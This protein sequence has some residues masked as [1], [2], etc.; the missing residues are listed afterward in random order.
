MIFIIRPTYKRYEVCTIIT[1]INPALQNVSREKKKKYVMCWLA[2]SHERW[3]MVR[4][5]RKSFPTITALID[6]RNTV[7]GV[8]YQH[9]AERFGRSKSILVHSIMLYQIRTYPQV[10]VYSIHDCFSVDQRHALVAKHIMEVMSK[11]Y[12]GF[13]PKLKPT[14]N[15]QLKEPIPVTSQ[16]RRS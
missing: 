11:Q 14:Y 8:N 1:V 12:F 6:A 3:K 2:A 4:Q 15:N 10:L 13:T 5:L 9:A 16:L 7:N